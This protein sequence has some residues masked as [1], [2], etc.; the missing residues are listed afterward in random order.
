LR[1]SADAE[2]GAACIRLA[3]KYQFG[4]GVTKDQDKAIHYYRKGVE[5]E[6]F[7]DTPIA[8]V[9]LAGI[10]RERRDFAEALKWDEV[11][12]EKQTKQTRISECLFSLVRDLEHGNPEKRISQD[13]VKAA[14]W[15]RFAAEQGHAYNYAFRLAGFYENGLGVPRD[16]AEAVRWYRKAAEKGN[17]EAYYLLGFKFR[18][19]EGVEQDHA[20]AAECFLRAVNVWLRLVDEW[21]AHYR[22]YPQYD[23]GR[24]YRDAEGDPARAY[25]WLQLAADQGHTEAQEE[26]SAL[27]A[28]MLS[29]EF[30]TAQ[31]LYRELEKRYSAKP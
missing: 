21:N 2:F 7:S 24:Y 31:C 26:V 17:P 18:R 8:P 4:A 3:V 16:K 12:A 15:C 28:S 1:Q 22:K 14:K 29:S 11:A 13:Y 23:L 19:G 25:G 20:E 5:W 27:A 6:R 10:F 30:K 9:M